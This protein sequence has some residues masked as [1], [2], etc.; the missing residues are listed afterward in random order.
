MCV[1]LKY[2]QECS[3]YIFYEIL[4]LKLINRL[5]HLVLRGVFFNFL[6]IFPSKDQ[7]ILLNLLFELTIYQYYNFKLQY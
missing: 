3:E 7:N 4:L 2:K 5:N 1:Y 6:M